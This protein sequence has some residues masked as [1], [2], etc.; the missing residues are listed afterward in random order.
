MESAEVARRFLAFFEERGHT[1]VPSASLVAEDPTLLLVPAGMVPFKPY[2]LGQRTPPA[3]RMTSAQKCVRT[4]D[5]DEVGKTTRHATFFQMLGNFSI[6]DYF[7]EGAIPY[8]WELLTRPVSDGGFGFPEDKLWVTVYLDDDE[9]ADIWHR[10]VGIPVERIQR[11]G[12]ADNYWHMG[13]PGPGG[14]CSE[15]YYD[16]GP[17]YGREG[18]PIADEDRY[19]E[20]W[21]LVFMQ[22]QLSAVRSKTDFDVAGPLPAKNIDTGMGLERMAAILQGVDN[23]YETDT[24]RRILD[25]A[26]E[27]TGTRYGRDRRADV[28]LRVVADHVR[29]GTMLVADGVIPANEGR[30]Y[31][32]RRLLRRAIRNLRLLGGQDAGLMH[33]LTAVAIAAMG[34]QYTELISTAANIHAVIDA[35]EERFLQTLR[36]GTAIFDAA[37]AETK[38]AGKQVLSGSQ[39]FTLHDTYGFPIDLTLEMAAEQGLSVDEEG[40]R[41]LLEEQRQRAKADAAAKKTGNLD[42]SVLGE[43]LDRAGGKVDFLGYHD[44][45]GEARVVGLLV[46]GASVP[47]AGAGTEVEVV[48]DRT[49]FYA[50]G[51]GQLADQ[52]RIRTGGGAEIEVHDVQS[53]LPG[54]IVHRGKVRAG[55]AQAGDTAFAEIDV[56][57]RRAISRSHT[58]THMVHAGFRRALGESAAQA[59][60]EN[61]PGRFRFDF[62]SAGPV[63]PSVLRDVEDEVNAVLV[64]DLDV[65]AFTTSI[66]QARAMGA[67]ALFGEKYG[68]E[69]RVVEVGD[70]SRELCGGTHVARSGQLGLI[71]VLGESSIGAGVRR[72]E[73]LVGIDAFRFLARESVLVSQLSE[74]L[75]VRKEELPERISTV[76]GRLREAEKELER[77]RSA[78]VL[79]VAGSLADSAK[80]IDGIAYVAHRAPD[81]T[82]ADDLRKLALDV[83]GRLASRPAVV[84]ITGVPKDRPVVVVAVTEGARERGLKAGALVGV[85]AK[86]L[87]GG[88]G[89]KDDLAQGG[90]ADPTAIDKALAAVEHAVVSA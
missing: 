30:G 8:A 70:Y 9:A 32:L 26:A 25:K 76:I 86:A 1:V 80:D 90:G 63:P 82:T 22:E 39:A 29:A 75:K 71:K 12:L 55:E 28:S 20:V 88:G 38:R 58:A 18:G 2:F 64:D 59:G 24:L 43:L 35:E 13:V 62:T 72:I 3:P 42:V 44:V 46:N 47:A 36:T 51:G 89:G 85:A 83:R 66:E 54:L 27:L 53:P 14:P 7:K 60:S 67:L 34:E 41:R 4:P 33:E 84:L 69:V 11:R 10:K 52:G 23:I 50:E 31:V 15:I 37:V 61:S 79:A 48:L 49:P 45:T 21:N 68:D 77:L 74:Q 6:G 19:L 56:E 40:F 16:R 81:G 65:R 57:R 73:A 78:Q 87:G 5:I 17:A